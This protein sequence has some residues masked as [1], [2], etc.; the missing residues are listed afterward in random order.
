MKNEE[1]KRGVV[2]LLL[3]TDTTDS[4]YYRQVLASGTRDNE[5]FAQKQVTNASP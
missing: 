4:T 3:G 1:K 2:V 5:D